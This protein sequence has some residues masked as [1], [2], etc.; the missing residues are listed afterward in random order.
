MTM[1]QQPLED[2][3]YLHVFPMEDVSA[4]SVFGGTMLKS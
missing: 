4:M 3:Q 1:E 2:V